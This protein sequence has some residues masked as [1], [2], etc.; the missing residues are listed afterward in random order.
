[1]QS[2]P[3]ANKVVSTRTRAINTYSGRVRV[4]TSVL[5]IGIDCMGTCR[6]NFIS[7]T[8]PIANKVVYTCTHAI[9][10]YS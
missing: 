8:I 5:A 10:T 4:D 3:I 7:Y 1:M 9:N 6:Y 2:I